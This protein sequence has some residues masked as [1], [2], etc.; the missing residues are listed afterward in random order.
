M[1]YYDKNEGPFHLNYCDTNNLYRWAMSQKLKRIK[2]LSKKID[3][4]QFFGK[5]I[6][7]VKN[8]IY[9]SIYNIYIYIYI[10]ISGNISCNNETKKELI[11]VKSY[12]ILSDDL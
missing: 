8:L 9:I 7:N 2:I 1:K 10:Y 5:T 12:S 4:Q 11:R 3:E 6:K